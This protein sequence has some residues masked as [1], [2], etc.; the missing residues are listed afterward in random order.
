MSGKKFKKLRREAKEHKMPYDLVKSA[1]KRL[2]S[3]QRKK[4]L[5]DVSAN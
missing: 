3:S 4:L 2:S 1:Y 5:S